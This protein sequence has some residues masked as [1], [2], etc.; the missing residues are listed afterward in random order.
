MQPDNWL[1]HAR[2]AWAL[3][4]AGQLQ[5]A[6]ADYVRAWEY[7]PHDQVLNWYRH[8]VADCECQEQWNTALWYLNRLLTGDPKDP[9]GYADRA[10]VYA[11][12]G[13]PEQR[14]ADLAKAIQLGAKSAVVIRWAD[15][16]ASRGQWKKAA[17]LYAE[18]IRRGTVMPPIWQHYA[19]VRL[20]T[21]DQA[22][23]RKVC[24]EMLKTIDRQSPSWT[25]TRAVSR[26]S[27]F[28]PHAL[29][30]YQAVIP[31]A[32]FAVH[33]LPPDRQLCGPKFW[34]RW[35]QCSTG[36]GARRRRL[37]ASRRPSLP[38]TAGTRFKT[39]CSLRWRIIAW[40][41]RPRP[42]MRWKKLVRFHRRL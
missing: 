10:A 18:A 26:A 36:P 15:E 4:T 32:E 33:Q 29:A 2:H 30:E 34:A 25:S 28:G 12:L 17:A 23:Y 3:S 5:Q 9:E 8:C 31:L 21:G 7:G 27:V 1:L 14:D 37:T 40:A 20:R 6:D 42:R 35:G 38:I 11:K 41:K 16:H 19:L 24:E 13:Q 39:G 22:G